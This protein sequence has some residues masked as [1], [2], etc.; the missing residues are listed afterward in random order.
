MMR[1]KNIFEAPLDDI[2]KIGDWDRNSSIRDPKDRRLIDN[3]AVQYKLYQSFEK[4]SV[5][6]VLYFVN[7]P[8]ANKHTEVGQ[9]SLKWIQS[10][11]DQALYDEIQKEI[12]R[13][14]DA[15]HIV[16]T[17]NKG[18][19]RKSLTAWIIA[20]RIGHVF[21]RGLSGDREPLNGYSS[22]MSQTVDMA[23]TILQD[24]FDV[25][26]DMSDLK[27]QIYRSKRTHQ[28]FFKNFMTKMCT[29]KSARDNNVREFFEIWN[30]LFAQALL[31]EVKFNLPTSFKVGYTTYLLKEDNVLREE[32]QNYAD[33]HARD[34]LYYVQDCFS[35]AATRI[36][37][38]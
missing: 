30:E 27:Y 33:M 36:F 16:F 26:Y 4:I 10:E 9:V 23:E 12:K 6:V 21:F 24:G 29:F 8:K 25:N 35:E 17:N 7:S 38:M 19:E 5:P 22:L 1:I 18:A 11:L 3:K 15:C 2:K 32:L 37:V 28:L 31:S 20:H 13:E 34:I 14:P